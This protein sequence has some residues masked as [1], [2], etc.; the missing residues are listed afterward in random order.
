MTEVWINTFSFILFGRLLR[1]CSLLLGAVSY[2]AAG[3]AFMYFRR[4]VRGREAIPNY[5]FWMS[6]PGLIK[7]RNLV[8]EISARRIAGAS[9]RCR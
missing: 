2:L 4:G 1:F 8:P 9:L 3:F 5:T 7:V 6:L